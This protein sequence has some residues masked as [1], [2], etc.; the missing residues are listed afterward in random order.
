[1]NTLHYGSGSVSK[2]LLEVLPHEKSKAFIITGNSLAT[3]T[4]LIKD[5]EKLLGERHAGTYSKIKQHAPVAQLD[6]ATDQVLK[7]SNIDT[8]ISIGG[9][10][11]IDSAKAISYRSN[12]KGGKFLY[13]IS[14]PTTLSAAEPTFNSG[15]TKEEGTKIGVSDPRLA[16]S[17]IIYD[18]KFALETPE[19]LWM[20]TGMRA[21][22]HAVELSYHPYLTEVPGRRMV[23]GAM[24]D[25]FKYLPKYKQNPKDEDTIT[26]LQLA[27]FSS[28]Y[29]IGLNSKGGLGLSHV[30]G[31]ALGSPYGIP[32]GIT[33]CITLAGVVAIKAEDPNSAAQLAR[34]LEAIG[35]KRTGDDK[36]DALTFS[37]E[38]EK[39]VKGLGLETRLKDYDVGED[40]I[41]K[42]TQTATRSTEGDMYEKVSRFVKSKM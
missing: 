26:R 37:K 14:I 3:K 42:I 16:P 2:H 40:Q 11:P 13:H 33:S 35:G 9:G 1:M 15:Y 28:I 6:E 31:Y 22:D 24:A 34:D 32:H 17:V 36:A 20:S 7:D 41:P 29:P 30:L 27:A 19:K 4:S 5:V 25:L 38:I 39:L 8:I 12:E 21:V 18:S 10:S 23:L